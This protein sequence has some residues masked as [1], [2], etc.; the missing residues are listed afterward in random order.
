MLRQ[1]L[2]A[3]IGKIVTPSDFGEYMVYHNRR[4]FADAYAPRPFSY[5]VRR[6][7]GH[8]PEGTL[9]IESSASTGMAQVSEWLGS[10]EFGARNLPDEWIA[11]PNLNSRIHRL[12]DRHTIPHEPP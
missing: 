5:D 9:S 4:L 2:I 6:T 8:S 1:Q 11:R 12:T 10:V 3:A 7:T